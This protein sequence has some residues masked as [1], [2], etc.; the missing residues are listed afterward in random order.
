M[1]IEKDWTT[2]SGLRAVVVWNDKMGFRCGYVQV[3]QNHPLHAVEY[4]Q[5]TEALPRDADGDRIAPEIHFDVHGCITYSDDHCPTMEPEE[6]EW[7]FGFDCGHVGDA[8]MLSL[9]GSGDVKRSLE[10]VVGQCEKLARQI[11]A[12]TTCTYG[13]DLSTDSERDEGISPKC[14]VR[15]YPM[16]SRLPITHTL[17]AHQLRVLNTFLDALLF[18]AQQYRSVLPRTLMDKIDWVYGVWQPIRD[19]LARQH[20][21]HVHGTEG[22][23]ISDWRPIETAPRDGTVIDVWLGDADEEDVDF[24]CTPGTRRSPAWGFIAG[25]FRPLIGLSTPMTTFVQPTHWMPMPGPPEET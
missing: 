23:A 1:T 2:E 22:R 24:Y 20:L 7:W 4:M 21:A 11:R 5:K 25:R 16:H 13:T 10:Y 3:P 17:D 19:E 15:E 8:T 18:H 14:H 6:G 9:P 12:V